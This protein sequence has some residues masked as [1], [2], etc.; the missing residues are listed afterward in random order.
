MTTCCAS[1]LPL[2]IRRLVLDCLY[3]WC[4]DVGRVYADNISCRMY[5]ADKFS[6]RNAVLAQRRADGLDGSPQLAILFL[7]CLGLGRQPFA[8]LSLCDD[9]TLSA[10]FLN[11]ALSV[12]W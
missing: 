8:I 3:R 6:T 10:G 11:I 7:Q 2:S 9:P 4:N 5:R 12:S 1:R